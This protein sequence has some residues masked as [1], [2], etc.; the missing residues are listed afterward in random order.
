MPIEHEYDDAHRILACVA[1]DPVTGDDWLAIRDTVLQSQDI[2]VPVSRI[3]LD[4]RHR[5]AFLRQRPTF[6]LVQQIWGRWSIPDAHWI[7]VVVSSQLGHGIG[8]MIQGHAEEYEQVQVFRE[9]GPA[10]AWLRSQYALPG[11]DLMQPST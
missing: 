5:R 9:M 11:P 2:P 7:A 3:L 8:R 1:R 6:M 4:F 10:R